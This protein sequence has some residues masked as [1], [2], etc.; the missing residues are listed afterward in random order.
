MMTNLPDWQNREIIGRNVLRPHATLMPFSSVPAAQTSSRGQSPFFRL[1]NGSW[2]FFYCDYVLDAPDDFF[3]PGYDDAGW[4]QIPVPGCWQFY[5]YGR[6]N[7]LN[8]RYPFPVDPPDV[9]YENAVGCYRT[10]FVVPDAWAGKRI[11]LSFGG[12]CSAFHVWVNGLLVGFSQGSHLPSEFDITPYIQKGGNVLAVKVYQWSYA[13]YLE[14]QDMWRLNGIFRD[15]CLIAEDNTAIRDVFAHATLDD[16]YTDGLLRAEVEISGPTDGYALRATL[17][18][19]H[20]AEIWSEERAAANAMEFCH[21]VP[22]ADKWSAETPC[23]YPLILELKKGGSLVSCVQIKVGFRKIEIKG[24]VF[25]VNGQ[26]IKLK[27][28]NRHDTHPDLG[29]AVPYDAMVKDIIVMKQHNINAVRTSHYPNDPRWL[30]LCD[31]YGLYVID[32]ADIETHGFWQTGQCN[33]ISDDPAWEKL[34]LDRAVRMVERDKNHPC[35][36][37]WS[38]GNESGIGCNQKAMSGWIK[39]RDNSRPIHYEAATRD[40]DESAVDVSSN[41]YASVEQCLDWATNPAHDKP[42]VQCEY[43]HAMGNSPGTLKEYQEIFYQYDAMMGGFI[44]EWAEHGMRETDQNGAVYFRYGG[45]Y[46]D[47]PHDGCFCIDGLC[48]PDRAPRP[49]LL[50]FKQ[51]IAP[52]NIS[53]DGILTGR[54]SITNRFDMVDLSGIFGRWELMRDGHLVQSGALSIPEVLPHQ[55]KPLH[56]PFD[57]D[58][59][60]CGHEYF[61][62]FRFF[63]QS[64]TLWAKAGHE[65]AHTQLKIPVEG[66]AAPAGGL[67]VSACGPLRT[68]E[69]NGCITICGDGF[70]YTFGRN[71]GTLTSAVYHGQELV[72]SGPLLNVFWAP[73]DN[74]DHNGNGIAAA[75]QKFGLH[76][77][78]H[79]VKGMRV[80]EK[81]GAAVVEIDAQL[82]APTY[83]PMFSVSYTYT[84]RPS[85]EIALDT[86]VTAHSPRYDDTA[87]PRLPKLGLKLVVPGALSTMKWYGRGPQESYPDKCEAAL[88]GLYEGQVQEQFVHYV[89]PQENGNKSDVRWASFTDL[90]GLGLFVDGNEPI[91]VSARYCTDEALAAA[92]HTNELEWSDDITLHIDHRVSGVG[93]ESCGSEPL[94]PYWVKAQDV[95][96]AIRL[97]PFLRAAIDE[98]TL[99]RT[100][101][102]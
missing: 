65:V 39:S 88:I 97:K 52:V 11:R 7:Y 90:Q 69:Q 55:T 83:R 34:F 13:S 17:K 71:L 57:R 42:F 35:I 46:G 68:S 15:V 16:T 3:A 48:T 86:N 67:P 6:K 66:A 82:C 63:L 76:R 80:L 33:R 95:Q 31:E 5:G 79:Y 43:A 14:S 102:A 53:D 59:L 44:W 19:A 84:V 30:D 18:D 20:G 54:V 45:D 77:M 73:T 1:L 64:D 81:A 99:Y 62:N 92:S 29:Y 36:L 40:G 91:H 51:V 96:F 37:L 70:C 2:K 47:W 41:M 93:S 38:L 8:I 22:K 26:N 58:A 74:D 56:V 21:T 101:E 100:K 87:L 50:N 78:R 72:K 32:E 61:V 75:W 12:V 60:I 89:R 25:L 98:T 4:G 23:L 10:S 24:R 85:G 27:G 49:G 9:P 28:V 94:E